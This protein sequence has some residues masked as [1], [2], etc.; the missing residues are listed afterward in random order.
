MKEQEKNR[1]LGLHNNSKNV[2]GRLIVE[3]KNKVGYVVQVGIFMTPLSDKVKK[4]FAKA[5]EDGL[6][7]KQKYMQS[8][9]SAYILGPYSTV[10][11]SELALYVARERFPD[12]F[13]YTTCDGRRLKANEKC[14]GDVATETESEFPNLQLSDSLDLQKMPTFDPNKESKV[15][16]CTMDGCAAYVS[17]VLGNVYQGN[18]WHAHR[19]GNNVYSAFEKAG[20][21][22]NNK[23]TNLFNDINRNPKPTE[24]IS[25]AKNIAKSLVPDQQ[26]F[27]N[28]KLNDVVGLFYEPSSMHST[29]F[30]EAM[31]GFNEMGGGTKA[32][33]GPFMIKADG[34]GQWTGE[35]L[36]KDIK[37]KPGKTLSKGMVPG[38]NTHLGFV[39]AI[40]NGEPIIFHNIHQ[41]VHATPLSEMNKNGT[42]IVWARRGQV[43]VEKNKETQITMD[44]VKDDFMYYFNKISSK[45]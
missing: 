45:L 28:L 3:A 4:L 36:G 22:N 17:D 1:I 19:M 24:G 7:I 23:I 34:S 20:T 6:Q 2:N 41:Q 9:L 27:S 13:K 33:D 15:Y 38:L 39:G 37:F 35:D 11:K 31:T 21:T 42:A 30:F 40:N 43:P 10:D 18:A 12:A 16:K 29:A 26:K 25:D 8:N 44:K 14:G 5:K 32:G